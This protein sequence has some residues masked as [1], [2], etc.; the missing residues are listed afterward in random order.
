MLNIKKEEYVLKKTI[1]KVGI[2]LATVEIFNIIGALRQVAN[3]KKSVLDDDYTAPDLSMLI[4]QLDQIHREA[5][6]QINEEDL[7]EEAAD[8][9]KDK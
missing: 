3:A 1:H 9:E 7:N 2:F 8:K 4:E 5:I 6:H